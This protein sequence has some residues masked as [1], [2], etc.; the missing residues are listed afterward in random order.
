MADHP[1]E[2][3]L[4]ART[5]QER[6]MREQIGA[7]VVR[8]RAG[9]LEQPELLQTFSSRSEAWAVAPSYAGVVRSLGV[10]Q[11]VGINVRRLSPNG[12][13]HI[14]WGA[15]GIYVEHQ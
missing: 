15:A 7:A 11:L 5:K 3:N 14:T 9:Q 12:Q 1:P 2:R 4:M 6:M 8:A 10:Q 13:G